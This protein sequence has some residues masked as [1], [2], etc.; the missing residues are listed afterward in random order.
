[1]KFTALHLSKPTLQS[2][3]EMG[4]TKMTQ[5]QEQAIPILLK[6]RDL[7]GQADT[8]T[9]KTAAFA[10][11]AIEQLKDDTKEIQVLVLCPTRELACQ[12]AD[13]FTQLMK[14]REGFT[15]VPIYGGQKISIQLKLIKNHPQVIVG[16]PG[17]V[18]DHV[19]QGSL[20]LRSVR[21]VILDEADKMLEMGFKDDIEHVVKATPNRKQTCLFSATMQP[22]I[23]QLAQKYQN[24]AQHINLCK[25]K[26]EEL[27]IKQVY[28]EVAPDLKIEAIKRLLA[29][30]RIRSALIFCNTR[31]QV[32]SVFHHLKEAGFSVASLHGDLEQRKR[33]AVMRKFREGE[34]R[35]L[36][37]TDIAARGIDVDDIEAV[38]NY[39]LPRDSQ[40]Y[41]HRIGRT[42]RAGKTGMAF[43]LVVPFE[44]K[45]LK[46]IITKQKLAIHRES[47]P[48]I[49]SLEISSLEV[50]QN[51]LIDSTISISTSKQFMKDIK[52]IQAEASPDDDV[53]AL[54]M[55]KMLQKKTH[56]FGAGF[57]AAIH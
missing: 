44:L 32:N 50:L 20:R 45:H 35:I 43:S 12:V 36:V 31:T 8:G 48:S 2:L 49:R 22:L 3:E 52:K 30:Y 17:R 37:A 6:G 14:H 5:I 25:N 24:K 39:N 4:F 7:I 33:D 46:E 16:T 40:D 42:G 23:L 13:Q 19:R 9:G 11:P 28:C 38:F 54:F 53:V 41:V 55:K 47:I 27:K 10:I 34:A 56:V 1:M 26:E 21:M 51:I 29:F 18:L 15:C 57:E